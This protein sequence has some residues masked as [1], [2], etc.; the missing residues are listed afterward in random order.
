MKP[1]KAPAF[2]RDGGGWRP[3]GRLR[4]GNQPQSE[5]PE[6]AASWAGPELRE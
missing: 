3:P 6:A 1:Q 2:G 4:D 5:N